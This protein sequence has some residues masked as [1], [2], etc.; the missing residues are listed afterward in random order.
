MQR[1]KLRF[2]PPTSTIPVRRRSWDEGSGTA[3]AVMVICPLE[4]LPIEIS[5]PV[6]SERPV[7]G[8]EAKLTEK[9]PPVAVPATS[10]IIWPRPTVTPEFNVMPERGTMK[11]SE[12][13]SDWPLVGPVRSGPNSEFPA[14]M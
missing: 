14:K 4:N 7:V 13:V 10:K 6:G 11:M 12:V 8:N 3:A 2:I 1:D 5:F 9:T